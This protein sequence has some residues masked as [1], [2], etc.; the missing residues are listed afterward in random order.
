MPWINYL[1]NLGFGLVGSVLFLRWVPDLHSGMR[2]YRRS[3]IEELRYDPRGAALPVEL[4]T[5]PIKIG[6][7]VKIV[8]IDYHER[9]GRSTMRPLSSAWWTLRRL[10]R[11]RFS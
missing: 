2:A 8:P 1:G 5:R 4:L 9:I 6:R 7:K 3:L 11:V 10:L